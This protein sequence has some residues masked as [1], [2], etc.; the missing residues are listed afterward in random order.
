MGPPSKVERVGELQ[1]R[2]VHLLENGGRCYLPSAPPMSES[3]VLDD[4]S[5]SSGRSKKNQRAQRRFRHQVRAQ[6]S[7]DWKN[8][9]RL[10]DI[11]SVLERV[12]GA[13]IDGSA[14]VGNERW[15]AILDRIRFEYDPKRILKTQSLSRLSGVATR[16]LLSLRHGPLD[17]EVRKDLARKARSVYARIPFW[18]EV[19]SPSDS[20]YYD[21]GGGRRAFDAA[22]RLFDKVL[23][24]GHLGRWGV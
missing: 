6:D 14:S 20:S 11:R 12:Y 10:L 19:M 2:V 21:G 22:R 1:A 3:I 23:A 5:G 18:G 24:T 4:S 7:H 17:E 15:E 13:Q 9:G 8:K 16:L